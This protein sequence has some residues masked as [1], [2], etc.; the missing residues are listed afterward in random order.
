[1]KDLN[2]QSEIIKN[3]ENVKTLRL[4]EMIYLGKGTF[5]RQLFHAFIC[6]ALRLFFR[7]IEASGVER[8]P[9]EGAIIFVLN[10]PNGAVDPGLV[11][12]SLPRRVSFLA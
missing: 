8:V 4:W 2:Q 9:R 3:P 10:H 5:L 12:V 1:M 7:R 6:V 11:F